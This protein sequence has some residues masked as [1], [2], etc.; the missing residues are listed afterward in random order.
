MADKSISEFSALT[1]SNEEIE[2]IVNDDGDTKKIDRA[3]L[4]SGNGSNL[5]GMSIDGL[6]DGV[7]IRGNIGLG[8]QTLDDIK[9]T[10]A[11]GSNNVAV[12]NSAL[13]DT[14][15]GNWNTAVGD[16]TLLVLDSK[17]RN[18]AIGARS[19]MGA[20]GTGN[21]SLGYKSLFSPDGDYNIGIGYEPI[22]ATSTAW[23]FSGSY[24]IGIGY[25]AGYVLSTGQYNFLGGYQ[26]GYA[27]TTGSN[28][29]FLGNTA[30]DAVETGSN[31]VI[32]GDYAG[33]TALAD[34][35]A[36]Y[37]GTTERMK[38]DSTGL[39]I[40]GAA[41][42]GG[43]SGEANVQVDWNETT[44]TDDAYI[45]NKPV[46]ATASVTGLATATQI[47]KLDGIEASANNYSHPSDEHLPSSVSQAEAGYLDGVTS[48]IQTQLNSKAASSHGT[49][50]TSN[51]V[52]ITEL[53]V[54]DGTNGQMLSTNGSGTLSFATA[55]GGGVNITSAATAPSSPTVG[56]QWFDT[57]DGILFTYMTDGTDSDWIDISSA[58][59][60]AAS[61][62]GGI[63]EF[64]STS[65]AI[66][67]DDTALDADDGTTNANIGIG[68]NALNRVEGG[69][70]NI[71]LGE[72]ALRLNVVGNTNISLGRLSSYKTTGNGNVALG[73]Q[74]LYNNSSG[75]YNIGL[76][77]EA[78]A[79]A[80]TSTG[81][82]NIGMG[83]QAGYALSTGQYNFLGG[84][85]A[86]YSLTTASDNV[87]LGRE[88]GYSHNGAGGSQIFI[89]E[90]AG[91][92]SSGS[93]GGDIGIGRE[94]CA[95]YSAGTG[96]LYNVGIQIGALGRLAGGSQNVAIGRGAG[97]QIT[98]ASDN[99]CLGSFS[100]DS[101]TTGSNN[102]M[103]GKWT[104][105]GSVSGT[106]R[107]A[108]GYDITV[109]SDSRIVIGEGNT[110]RIYN[111]F[112]SS[113]TWT[114]SSDVRLKTEI[115]DSSIGLGFINDLRPVKYKWKS[116]TSKTQQYGLIAQEVK[117]A[118][119]THGEPEFTVW[120]IEDSTPDGLQSLAYENLIVPLI[121][122]VQELT[123]RVKHLENERDS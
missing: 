65:I 45:L 59:G 79:G 114:R 23:D 18:T 72:L 64:I 16:D 29:I 40:N 111:T 86:G 109:N 112:S 41:V 63:G 30:G 25:Q 69:N 35:V 10:G 78:L 43:G 32:I 71:A 106:N 116:D 110:N 103:L 49:H 108:I 13:F 76:G 70:N 113:A 54:S 93:G 96:G 87:Y 97:S 105:S 56:D 24:N 84:Y 8:Y 88:A 122:A 55:S 120:D 17:D 27:L 12:G 83:Y 95:G 75:E 77:A 117:S 28:N 31:N 90:K 85:T 4:F 57:T 34:T 50:L 67:S 11:T 42:G 62:G 14:E 58:N 104:D 48:A 94:T 20:G 115:E 15:D 73:N 98:T 21:T 38:I 19:Q 91:K 1:T 37:A 36:I 100:G 89:G 107:I 9:T 6:S 52:G 53:N 47:T 26:A 121:K 74:A 80:S 46:D 119:D 3:T 7:Y 5:T 82:Y 2:F 101:I 39:T 44:T 66:S 81:S 61:S 60:L 51:S 118:M 92:Y 99:V 22:S 102:I 33:T 123:A 68:S